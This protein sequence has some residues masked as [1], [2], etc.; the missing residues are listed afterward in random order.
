MFPSKQ[1][2]KWRL[3][4]ANSFLTS[5]GYQLDQG[6]RRLDTWVLVHHCSLF[7]QFM[8]RFYKP[9]KFDFEDGSKMLIINILKRSWSNNINQ[10]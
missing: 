6:L 5:T 2:T 9:Y 3:V 1:R 8:E 10:H 4:Q 7:E